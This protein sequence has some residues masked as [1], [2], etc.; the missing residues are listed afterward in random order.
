M[1]MFCVYVYICIICMCVTHQHLFNKSKRLGVERVAIL[2]EF[3]ITCTSRTVSRIGYCVR[4][5]QSERREIKEFCRDG[6]G[7]V[8]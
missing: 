4:V 2:E 1:Y 8:T 7:Y 3:S 6:G 5:I